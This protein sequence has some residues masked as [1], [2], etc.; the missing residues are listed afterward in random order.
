LAALLAATLVVVR[1]ATAHAHPAESPAQLCADRWNWT[2]YTHADLEGRR[3]ATPAEVLASPCRVW[4]R[5]GGNTGAWVPCALDA[6]RVFACG[7]HGLMPSEIGHPIRANATYSPLTGA[8][9]LDGAK[10]T[11][12]KKPAWV[13]RWHWD[14]GFIYPFDER[15]RVLPGIAVKPF[16]S[17]RVCGPDFRGSLVGNCGA[18]AY[19]IF[20]RWPLAKGDL[21]VYTYWSSRGTRT[22]RM[23]EARP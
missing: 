10:P 20:P 13:T 17:L 16:R 22:Y 12:V 23:A 6:H 2:H 5:Y 7:L 11:A 21:F 18:G 14:Q 15:G 19:E 9:H 8:I 1:S 4:V 3:S